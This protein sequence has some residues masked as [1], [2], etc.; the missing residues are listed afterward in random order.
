MLKKIVKKFQPNPLDSLL[1]K[2]KK[3]KGRN[4]LLAWNRGLG[5]IALGLYAI[6]E[7][8]YQFLPHAQIT[9]LIRP[10]LQEGFALFDKVNILV[11]PLWER[12]KPYDTKKTLVELGVDPD[13]FDLIIENPSP[14]DW[15]QWQKG[16]IVP[17]L[18]WKQAF[19][20]FYKKFDVP[21]KKEYIGIQPFVETAYGLWR[22]WPKRRWD[23]LFFLLEK[24]DIGVFLFGFSPLPVFSSSCVIDMR[25]KTNLFDMLSLAKKYCSSFILPDSGILSMIYYLDIDVSWHVLSLW[26]DPGHGILKQGV[27][28][29]NPS[30]IHTPIIQEKK[31]LKF[32]SAKEVLDKLIAREKKDENRYSAYTLF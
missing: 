2:V 9:F 20:E 24:K 18:R 8:I 27:A 7:R 26:A 19:E 17:K 4:I 22:N 3:R 1:K 6:V 25:G 30:L 23:E 5:D 14:T 15:V 13:A 21:Q 28:S 11:A 10:N 12:K 29:P 31:D 32:L 16:K